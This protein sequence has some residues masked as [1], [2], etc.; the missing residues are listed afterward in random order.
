METNDSMIHQ[1]TIKQSLSNE[2]YRRNCEISYWKNIDLKHHDFRIIKGPLKEAAALFTPYWSA[3]IL[4]FQQP[5]QRDIDLGTTNSCV[6][7]FQYGK[8]EIIANDQGE[9][10]MSSMSPSLT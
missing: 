2:K 7:V 9:R 10:T 4:M 1:E 3:M 8:V 5:C 6:R